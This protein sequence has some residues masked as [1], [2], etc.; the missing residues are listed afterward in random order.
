[1]LK[2][3]D[4]DIVFREIPDQTTLAIN[5]SNCPHRCVGCHSP[6][7]QQ[8]IGEILNEKTLQGIID[9]YLGFIT[10]VCFMGGDLDPQSVNNLACFVKQNYNNNLKTGWYSGNNRL[11]EKVSVQN[12]DYIKIGSYNYKLGG[13]DSETTNQR[14]YKI[15]NLNL[16]DVTFRMRG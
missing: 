16:L 12:F 14:I 4:Y 8:D 5:L 1:M 6:Q 13:L 9:K 10:C 11:S 2:Y 15:E 7:L 3:T